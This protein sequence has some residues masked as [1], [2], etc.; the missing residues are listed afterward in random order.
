MEIFNESNPESYRSIYG[1]LFSEF[2][3]EL[4]IKLHKAYAGRQISF[5]KKLYTEEYISYYVEKNK[6]K[7]PPSVIADNLECTERISEQSNYRE[8][9]R[10]VDSAFFNRS[11]VWLDFNSGSFD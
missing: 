10:Y 8:N 5:P 7:K 4:T 2:G 6:A 11:N 9:R 1:S 3:E